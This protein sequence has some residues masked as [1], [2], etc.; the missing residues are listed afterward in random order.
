MMGFVER[1]GLFYPDSDTP[2]LNK[3]DSSHKGSGKRSFDFFFLIEQGWWLIWDA[4]VL[5][6][7]PCNVM[8]HFSNTSSYRCWEFKP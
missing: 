7:R 8:A 1:K 2:A 4:I 5:L 3:H 6:W